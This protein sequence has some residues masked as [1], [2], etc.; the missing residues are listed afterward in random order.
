MKKSIA[1]F[2]AVMMLLMMSACGG[3]TQPEATTTTPPT[4][5]VPTTKTP[6]TTATPATTP[7]TTAPEEDPQLGVY[8]DGVYTNAFLGVKWT[9]N[10]HW[11][12]H[13][14][15]EMAQLNGLV[16]DAMTDEALAEQLKN[17][18]VAYAFY[19]TADE[20]L[21]TI[22]IALENLGLLYGTLL[23]EKSYVDISIKQ[24]PDALEAVGLQ[25]VTAEA[26]TLTFA[27]AEH[28]GV[29]VHG[30][31]SGVDFYEKLVCIK[32]GSYMG[33]VTVASYYEDIT[34]NLLEMFATP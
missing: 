22:N 21:V 27:G 32:S 20:G 10:E 23:D 19:A 11:T 26:T 4:T 29:T 15:E 30:S 17:S 18:G 12:V 3:E 31:I 5:T 13:S 24:L 28:A 34:E 1:W 9:T 16:A 7:P 33:I 14:K 2:L 8:A 25:N 6:P